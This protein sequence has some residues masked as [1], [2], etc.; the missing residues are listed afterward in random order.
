VPLADGDPK[1]RP[2]QLCLKVVNNLPKCM[3]LITPEEVI[4][5]IEGYFRG[6]MC[7]YLDAARRQSQAAQPPGPVLPSWLLPKAFSEVPYQ[8]PL[9]PELTPENALERMDAFIGSLNEGRETRGEGRETT[10]A[11]PST[12]DSRLSTRGIVICGGG[13]KYFPCAWV[14]ISMLR[15]LGCAL[16]IQ[17]WAVNRAEL[18]A[19]MEKLVAPL[20]VECIVAADLLERHPL[21][22]LGGWEVKPYTILHSPFREVLLLDADNVPLRN[23]EFLFDLPEYQ[24]AGAVFWPDRGRLG[25]AHRVWKYCGLPGRDEP[26]VESGQLLVDKNKCWRELQLTLWLNGH[27]DFFY[28]HVHGDKETFHLAWRKL[29]RDYAMT[30]HPVKWLDGTLCQHDFSGARLFQHRSAPKWQVIGGNKSVPGFQREAECLEFLRELRERW[31]CRSRAG[32]VLTVPERTPAPQIRCAP[33]G[34]PNGRKVITMILYNRP[35]Y[36]RQVLEALGRCEG[37]RR[38]PHPAAH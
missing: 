19:D 22:R 5:R 15:R 36:T 32:T 16:P 25:A 13:L 20:G 24:A 38:L 31:D 27:S 2:E 11:R 21:R 26:D 12:F 35:D 30:P 7:Q 18:D 34:P 23:P 3:D 1:D 37:N 10:M 29:G 33:A 8:N 9:A 17:L 4:R 14:C 28:R 6:G